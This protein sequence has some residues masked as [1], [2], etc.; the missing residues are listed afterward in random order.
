MK[1]ALYLVVFAVPFVAHAD[2]FIDWL[3]DLIAFV[4]NTI[5]PLIFVLAFL[6]FIWNAFVFFILQGTSEEGRE[7]A[8]R[9]M[10]WGLIALVLMITIW[11]VVNL[12]TNALGLRGTGFVIPDYIEEF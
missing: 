11:G 2:D 7:K 3:F 6:F 12:L 5:I 9:L 4:N 1:N 10:L 8:K